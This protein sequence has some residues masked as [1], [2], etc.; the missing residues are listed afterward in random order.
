MSRHAYAATLSILHQASFP[1]QMRPFMSCAKLQHR[2]YAC[3]IHVHEAPQHYY[4][5]ARSRTEPA[6]WQSS[7][8][9]TRFCH[10]ACV[11]GASG[12]GSRFV[13]RDLL[14]FHFI[15]CPSTSSTTQLE[16]ASSSRRPAG[17][18]CHDSSVSTDARLFQ[19]IRVIKRCPSGPCYLSD[20]VSA[21][22]LPELIAELPPSPQRLL[23]DLI[24]PW[25]VRVKIPTAGSLR[26]KSALHAS[27]TCAPRSSA[28]RSSLRPVCPQNPMPPTPHPLPA[29]H[30]HCLT[31]IS[32]WRPST[33][34]M[35]LCLAV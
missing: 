3:F 30:T 6:W 4:M 16:E 25:P 20:S 9:I 31:L 5:Q 15:W 34:R 32:T 29:P 14:S 8:S 21:L 12:S 17:H 7:V 1:Q 18:S 33:E 13:S 24:P 2:R 19:P 35:S 23:S 10:P 28:L 26:T 22:P 11:V 27:A